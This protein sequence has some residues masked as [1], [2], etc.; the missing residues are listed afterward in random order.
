M[1]ELERL[2]E[3]RD[4]GLITDEEFEVKRKEII[5]VSSKGET[6]TEK[7]PEIE[8]TFEKS[9]EPDVSRP[10][11]ELKS[12][13]S[14]AEEFGYDLK[15]NPSTGVITTTKKSNSKGLLIGLLAV[16]VAVIIGVAVSQ[17][18]DSSSSSNAGRN[19]VSENNSSTNSNNSTT[20]N[21]SANCYADNDDFINSYWRSWGTGVI[22]G[23]SVLG[24]F[25]ERGI[26]AG[27]GKQT[28]DTA[29][30][31]METALNQLIDANREKKYCNSANSRNVDKMISGM[32]QELRG[33]K[34][35]SRGLGLPTSNSSRDS[36]LQ[37]GEKD[38]F[39][40]N[41]ESFQAFCALPHNESNR[42][43]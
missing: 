28:V 24:S 12:T 27:R 29:V 31:K 6:P 25:T 32:Q 43:C 10:I 13:A 15:T 14:V 33:W 40:G 21:S 18:G 11:S 38:I 19:S 30:I 1:E 7:P 4:K 37:N 5:N 35:F 17:G 42:F 9:A 3:L 8:E 23:Q 2:A 22:S 39:E 26:F 36:V 20:N 41:A 16:V 34:E